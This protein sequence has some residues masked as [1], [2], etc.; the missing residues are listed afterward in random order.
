MADYYQILEVERD[1][2]DVEIKK[3]YRKLAIK[4]H[5]DR[6]PGDKE[7]E[8]KFKE[9]AQAYEVLGNPEKRQL[10]DQYGEAAFQNGGAG[11]QGFGNPFD[12]FR[13]VFGGGRGGDSIFESFFGGGFSR[14]DPN[15]PVDGN[16]LRYNLQIEFE[17]AVFGCDKKI[18]FSRKA[19]CDACH[20]TGCEAGTGRKKCPTCGGRGQVGVSQGFFTVMNECPKCHGEGFI[21]EHPCK[22][23][24]GQGQQTVERVVSVHIPPGVDTGTRMRVA[25]E[26]EPGLRGG[27]N[28][29]LFVVTHVKEHSVF[30]RDGLSIY[31]DLPIDF[32]TA[33]LGGKVDV[34]TVTGKAEL[35]IPAGA[36][37]GDVFTLKGK[38]MPSLR[39]GGRGDQYVKIFVEVPKS[40]NS[41][42]KEAL[43]KFA[44]LM[45]DS[46][47][48]RPVQ[49]SFFEKAKKFFSTF[50]F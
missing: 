43:R 27:S 24:R 46:K 17:E 38:G 50:C 2:T 5:P 49:E 25:G 37:T 31:C 19:Q 42:Q 10:Y 20:G 9:I 39:G 8:R 28:G 21:A 11:A 12:I 32:T 22:K 15:A 6:N 26:G 29:D 41:E 14:Q 33:A 30:Q 16:D 3:A 48:T 40:L 45:K 7:A 35:D 1:V 34:P 18:R 13:D 44:D 36:Q 4:Y 23:C 47:G